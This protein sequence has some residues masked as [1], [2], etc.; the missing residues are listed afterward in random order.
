MTSHDAEIARIREEYQR[1]HREIPSDY[2][3][4]HHPVNL[5]FRHTE[6]RAFAAGLLRHGLLPLGGKKV[7]EVGCGYG[8]L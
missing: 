2:Y 5:F 6:E 7:L 8:K 4:L 3:A 1:R